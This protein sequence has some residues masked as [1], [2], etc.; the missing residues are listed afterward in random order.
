MTEAAAQVDSGG[1]SFCEAIL[2]RVSRSFAL[3]IEAL[4][5]GLREA[6]RTAYLLCRV[7]DSVEDGR[8]IET[9]QREELFDEFDRLIAAAAADASRFEAASE[10]LELLPEEHELC[11]NTTEVLAAFGRLPP[12]AQAAIRPNLL[13]MSRGMREYSARVDEGGGVRI[14]DLQDLERYC[15]FVAGTVGRLLTALFEDSVPRLS[16]ERRRELRARATAF[17]TG[18]QMVNILKDAA[19][20][21]ARGD[22]FLPTDHLARE[23]VVPERL[24]D[25]IHRPGALRA[26]ARVGARAR[27]HLRTATEYTLLWPV[28]DGAAVRLFCA[29]PLALAFATLETV[30][31]G[32]DALRAGRVPKVS[33]LATL[34]IFERARACAADQAGLAAFLEGMAGRRT[35]RKRTASAGTD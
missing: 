11:R 29:V 16:D 6:V 23:G 35:S 13:E 22:C 33:R 7:V 20:D 25:P 4:P 15:Y 34:Q 8:G 26:A 5:P 12:G 30:A 24:L 19:E 17:G 10:Q 32:D 18:L 14:R 21:H 28:P 1:S 3:S 2:P 9:R 31:R 27:Q